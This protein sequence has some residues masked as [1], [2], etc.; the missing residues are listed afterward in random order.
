MAVIAVFNQKGGVG[1]TTTCLNLTAALSL[2]QRS[3]IALDMDPQGHLSLASGLK[4]GTSQA[5]SIVSFFKENTPLAKL[6]YETPAGW[7]LIPATL[8]LSKIDALYGSDPQA[9]KM[10]K[11]GLAEELSLTGAP[12]LIDCCPTLGVLTL[13]ALLAAD[14]VL[15]PVSADYLSQ[16][17]VH[18]L[19][20]ALNVLE[21]KL[22]RKF[23]RRI[24]VTRFDSRRKLSF[25]IYDQLRERYG[26]L[27]CKTRIGETVALAT[28]P[29]HG[30]DVFAYAPHSPGAADYRA[31]AKELI[32]SG[33]V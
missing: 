22:Q 17:G 21:K 16:H 7:Q 4:H 11:Q 3:P 30:L 12:I 26:D 8:E 18:R 23:E 5:K 20:S 31:L 1:K 24:V 10:L 25:D 32:D 28:S 13:N 33:F 2:A 6:L 9:A 19:D 27:L 15:I 14:K 29:M